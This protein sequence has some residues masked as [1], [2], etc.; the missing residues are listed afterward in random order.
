MNKKSPVYYFWHIAT[1][2]IM[3]VIFKFS[4]Q[5]GAESSS[6]SSGLVE[7]LL[8]KPDIAF[9][10]FMQS[11]GISP[12]ASFE[13]ILRKSAHFLEYAALGFC[14]AMSV[15]RHTDD[16]AQVI[17]FAL[18]FCTLYAA[19]D[20]FHQLFS[21]NRSCSLA[22]VLIDTSGIISG[23]FTAALFHFAKSLSKHKFL[24]YGGCKNGKGQKA[25]S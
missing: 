16:I 24:I 4:A 3:L 2:I 1:V 13:H 25:Q 11:G 8:G 20:E 19:S 14:F 5:S 23:I 22:D 12:Y 18:L 21:S 6:T 17:S 9:A 7:F 15:Y 10:E